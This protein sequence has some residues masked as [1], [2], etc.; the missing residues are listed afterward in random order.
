M[1]KADITSKVFSEYDEQFQAIAWLILLLLI[2][3][4]CVLEF[5]NPRLKNVRLFSNKLIKR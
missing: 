5:K 2:A 4:I 1:A 3:D